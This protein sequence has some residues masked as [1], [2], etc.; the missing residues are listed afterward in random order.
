M[1]YCDGFAWLG[2]HEVI[3]GAQ[4]QMDYH[5]WFGLCWHLIISRLDDRDCGRKYA[6]TIHQH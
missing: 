4:D 3:A 5:S 2:S 6:R 1:S